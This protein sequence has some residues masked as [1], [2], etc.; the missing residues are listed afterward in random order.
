LSNKVKDTL[1]NQIFSA[2]FNAFVAFLFAASATV[3]IILGVG[4][5][6]GLTT[7]DVS[8]R[9]QRARFWLARY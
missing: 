8:P 6:G 4:L 5:Q 9:P 3:V 2:V 1:F 7:S